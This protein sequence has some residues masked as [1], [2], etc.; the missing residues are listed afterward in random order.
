MNVQRRRQLVGK[1]AHQRR[2]LGAVRVRLVMLHLEHTHH[3]IA[4]SQPD[5]HRRAHIG[6][7]AVDARI[8][9][10]VEYDNGLGIIERERAQ[11]GAV[12][13]R[14]LGNRQESLAPAVD[15]EL[16]VAFHARDAQRLPVHQAVG[17]RFD[18]PDRIGEAAIARDHL[19]HRE[20]RIE[21]LRG[22]RLLDDALEEQAAETEHERDDSAARDADHLQ[23]ADEHGD[24]ARARAVREH[25]VAQQQRALVGEQLA[26]HEEREI[27]Q[28]A[29]QE[30][31]HEEEQRHRRDELRP[32]RAGISRIDGDDRPRVDAVRREQREPAARGARVVAAAIEQRAAAVVR[33][34]AEQQ[35]VARHQP[36]EEGDGGG[37]RPRHEG[38][39]GGD[40]AEQIDRAVFR[41]R[42]LEPTERDGGAD[43]RD[44]HRHMK[45]PLVAP[46]AR[47]VVRPQEQQHC[48]GQGH[49]PRVQCHEAG[50]HLLSRARR[51]ARRAATG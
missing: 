16:P 42:Q 39:A 48:S 36:H 27:E 4:E 18:P 31:V 26:A 40:D 22:D 13:I 35:H 30:E 8:T 32:R 23:R 7:R 10:C 15:H 45:R 46:P 17:E 49:E 34:V 28:P 33:Q 51:R 6:A 24:A 3:A 19:L 29:A 2:L 11:R 47:V 1:T 5:R 38:A 41:D 44:E 37:G 14:R 9:R 43:E 21:L 25:L 20:D 50:D 12:R